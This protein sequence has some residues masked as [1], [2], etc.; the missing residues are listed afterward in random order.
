MSGA[1]PLGEPGVPGNVPHGEPLGLPGFGV[2]GFTVEGCVLL[3][4]VGGF[5]EL[6][7]GTVDGTGGV[8]EPAGG[9]ADLDGGV[10]VPAGGVTVPGV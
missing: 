3:P 4:G 9:V 5:G 1:E 8:V 6:E 10:A 7:P 2:F